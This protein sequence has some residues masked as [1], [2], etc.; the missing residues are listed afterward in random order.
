MSAV[1]R[2]GPQHDHGGVREQRLH[3]FLAG[4]GRNNHRASGTQERDAT[5][6]DRLDD[7]DLG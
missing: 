7:K 5:V 3:R 2:G 1:S 6:V 4:V